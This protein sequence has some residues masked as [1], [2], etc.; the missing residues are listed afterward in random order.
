MIHGDKAKINNFCTYNDIYNAK[1]I[2]KICHFMRFARLELSA[3]MYYTVLGSLATKQ[4]QK[5]GSDQTQT[6]K[7]LG[8]EVIKLFMFNSAK[9]EIYTAHKC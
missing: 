8:P 1:N 2:N 7:Y 6:E 9:H 5:E 4:A 3:K